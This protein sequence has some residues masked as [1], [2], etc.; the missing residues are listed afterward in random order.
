MD[1][2]STNLDP[3]IFHILDSDVESS[4]NGNGYSIIYTIKYK[5]RVSVGFFKLRL[6]INRTLFEKKDFEVNV[7]IF[8]CYIQL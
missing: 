2:V 6:E 3:P 1:I 7:A 8:N 4:I 5:I